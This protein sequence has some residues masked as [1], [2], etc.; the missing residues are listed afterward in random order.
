MAIFKAGQHFAWNPMLSGQNWRVVVE[1]IRERHQ[2][3]ITTKKWHR[4]YKIL[5]GCRHFPLCFLNYGFSIKLHQHYLIAL[6]QDQPEQL[7]IPYEQAIH[8]SCVY[9]AIDTDS[10]NSYTCILKETADIINT[11]RYTHN[12]EAPLKLL[13]YEVA[14]ITALLTD[15]PVQHQY[16][17]SI[18]QACSDY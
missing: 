9:T 8:V 18:L 2:S 4:K 14:E 3:S 10:Q 16:S 17:L 12:I 5:S 7:K 1:T 15:S 11:C 13:A 6:T